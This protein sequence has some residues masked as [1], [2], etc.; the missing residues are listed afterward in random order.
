MRT[1]TAL[2]I[3]LVAAGL[4]IAAGLA[5]CQYGDLP[6]LEKRPGDP[7]MSELR[8]Q[9]AECLEQGGTFAP[10]GLYGHACFVEMPDAGKACRRATDCTGTCLAETRS[11]ARVEPLFGCYAFLD[12]DGNRIDICV[13]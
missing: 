8:K 9:Q 13:D 3:G 12:A 2:R 4:M 5:A 10:A 11:C 7:P 6:P 1:G